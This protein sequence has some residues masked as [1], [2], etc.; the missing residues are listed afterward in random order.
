[1]NQKVHRAAMPGVLDL[2][3]VLQLVVDALDQR[4]FTQEQAIKG[5][6]EHGAHVLAQFGDEL[7]T[8][9]EQELFSERRR[10]IALITKELAEEA[11]YQA[12]NGLAVVG[13]AGSETKGQQLSAVVHDQMEFEAV[14]PADRGLAAP[15]V[16]PEDPMVVDAR[17]MADGECG[18][19][20]EADAATLPALR[21][22][23]DRERDQD[24]GEQLN[25]AIIADEV[26]ELGAQMH[27][28]ILRVEGFERAVARLLKEDDNGDD[29]TGRQP[30]RSLPP[31]Y[32]GWLRS[33]EFALPPRLKDAPKRIYGAEQVEYT[34]ADTSFGD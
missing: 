15:G 20:N 32:A 28:D 16:S 12:G 25:E 34:H 21:V 23:I 2:A 3:D 9:R 19:V 22:Q 24:P 33:Q 6:E 10:E 30:R 31:S 14:K 1:M 11:T 17:W 13:I 29:L 8:L 26:R 5:R 27:L 18:R 4:P 7:E